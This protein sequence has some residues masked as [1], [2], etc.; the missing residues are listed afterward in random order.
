MTNYSKL[1]IMILRIMSYVLAV[2]SVVMSI[3]SISMIMR[4]DYSN[5]GAS[6][7]LALIGLGASFAYKCSADQLRSIYN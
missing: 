1:M 5:A 4:G 7:V 3:V 6:F 2:T